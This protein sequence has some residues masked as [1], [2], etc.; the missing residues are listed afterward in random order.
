MT[1]SDG[2]PVRTGTTTDYGWIPAGQDAAV[3]TYSDTITIT[4]NF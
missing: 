2:Q 4:V 3:G 1:V